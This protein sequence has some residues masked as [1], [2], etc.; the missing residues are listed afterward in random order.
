MEEEKKSLIYLLHKC[1]LLYIHLDSNTKR[2]VLHHI[3]DFILKLQNRFDVEAQLAYEAWCEEAYA[4]MQKEL[5]IWE[6]KM[7][8]S[9]CVVDDEWPLI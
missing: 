4:E 9:P 6:E 1:S 8:N 3:R 5:A 2:D 7:K